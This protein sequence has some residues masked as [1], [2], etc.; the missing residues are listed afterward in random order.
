M[1]ITFL[2]TGTSQGIPII[3][4]R[5]AVCQSPDP[6][7]NRLRSSI[8]VEGADTSLVIDTGPDFRQ[9]M[10]R[11]DVQKLDAVVFTHSHK[12]HTAGLDDIRAYNYIQGRRMDVWATE[13]TQAVLRREFAYAF[14]EPLYP[15]VP[16][17]DLHPFTNEPFQVYGL[18]LE[19]VR[20]WHARLEV[21]GFRIGR[22]AYITDANRIEPEE[23][24]KLHDLDVLV[25][26]ALRHEPHPSHFTLGEAVSLAQAVGARQ[27]YFTHISH[28]LGRHA[29]VDPHLPA[30]MA[31]AYDGLTLNL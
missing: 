23:L 16:E 8:W 6:R 11:A 20:V 18:A 19:P 15:G 9:Q 14:E 22:F 4:C 21:F 13:A 24:Q 17:M 1:K 26:N 29:D 7:D 30:G 3:G 28:Q 5:C 2:G 27:T 31:L 10:L 25:L 12:D